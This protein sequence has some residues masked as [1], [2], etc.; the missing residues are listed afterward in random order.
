VRLAFDFSA[1]AAGYVR[2]CDAGVAALSITNSSVLGP[3]MED[4]SRFFAIG[5]VAVNSL[6]LRGA[7]K[8]Q[9]LSSTTY[10]WRIR[11]PLPASPEVAVSLPVLLSLSVS[12]TLVRPRLVIS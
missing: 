5:T 7:E 12:S 4:P 11:K 9:P 3:V 2:R 1:L 10:P 8:S 6:P